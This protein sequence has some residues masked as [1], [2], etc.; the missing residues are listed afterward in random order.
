LKEF[1]LRN[2]DCKLYFPEKGSLTFEEFCNAVKTLSKDK[3]EDSEDGE[4]GEDEAEDEEE[5]DDDI[6]QRELKEA[7]KLYDKE[8]NGFIP[9]SSLKEILATLDDQLTNDQL[10]GER[11]FFQSS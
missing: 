4:G 5:D 10:C 9:T 1:D 6:L 7:F 11:K 8:G 3:A 2:E